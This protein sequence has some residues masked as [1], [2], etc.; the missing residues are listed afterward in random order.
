MLQA[1]D[2]TDRPTDGQTLDH[3]IDPATYYSRSVNNANRQNFN[4]HILGKH[5]SAHA[6]FLEENLCGNVI[7]IS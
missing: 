3:Y 4:G 6:P 1:I 2:G 5:G 7:Q